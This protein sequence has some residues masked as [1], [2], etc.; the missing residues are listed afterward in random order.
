VTKGVIHL[1]AGPEN[2]KKKSRQTKR[3][4]AQ[5]LKSPSGYFVE[6]GNKRLAAWKKHKTQIEA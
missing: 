3:Y 1:G 6:R 4:A 5:P 2:R